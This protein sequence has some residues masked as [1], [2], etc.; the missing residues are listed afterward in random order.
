MLRKSLIVIAAAA[1][2][3]V[4]MTSLSKPASADVFFGFGFN[5]PYYYGFRHYRYDDDYYGGYRP[6]CFLRTVK[7]WRHH[8]WVWR[9]VRVCR[10]YH[11]YGY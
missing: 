1:T 9:K 4:G 7:V 2:M 5:D 11:H 10:G 8:R 6:R 3:V